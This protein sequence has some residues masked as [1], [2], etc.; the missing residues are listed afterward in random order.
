MDSS[1]L[2]GASK[3]RTSYKCRLQTADQ[4]QNAACRLQNADCRLQTEYKIQTADQ[5]IYGI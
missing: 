3:M 1:G 5:I 4:I 2:S